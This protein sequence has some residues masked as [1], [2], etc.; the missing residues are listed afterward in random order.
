M[1]SIDKIEFCV[2]EMKIVTFLTNQRV[3][4][5][6]YL[7]NKLTQELLEMMLLSNFCAAVV[8]LLNN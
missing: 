1:L 3:P 2:Q 4:Q 5:T 6:P 7:I 8:N